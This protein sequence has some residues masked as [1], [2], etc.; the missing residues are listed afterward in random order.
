MLRN[1]L[2]ES[3]LHC[4]RHV[5]SIAADVEVGTSLQQGPDLP[6]S[7]PEP[8]LDIHLPGLRMHSS[9]SAGKHLM[10]SWVRRIGDIAFK[11]VIVGQHLKSLVQG[12]SKITRAYNG[13][14]LG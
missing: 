2:Q 10:P 11:A 9:S 12:E 3:L 7:L 8:V 1:D 4:H 14:I 6:A 13:G 5:R